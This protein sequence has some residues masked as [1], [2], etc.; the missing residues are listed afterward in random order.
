[1]KTILIHPPFGFEELAGNTASMK[2]VMNIIPP[3]G[4]CYIAAVLEENGKEVEIIDCT[5]VD[6][7]HQELL[8]ELERKKPDIVGISSTTP[9]FESTLKTAG[10]VRAALP[11]AIVVIGGVHVT[12]LP[13]ETLSC[14][15][16]DVGV[17]GEGEVTFLELVNHLESK[18]LKDLSKVMG[19]AYR[20]NNRVVITEKRDFIKDLDSLPLPARHLLPSL[21][22][23]H[24]TPASYR[25]LPH[26]DLMTSRGCPSL[27]TF[28][29]RAVFGC[30][31]RG[32]SAEN[33][34]DEVEELIRKYR[35]RDIKFFDDT[36]T[37]DRRRL[38]RICEL[39]HERGIDIP[40]SCLTKVNYV[41]KEMLEKM[42]KAGC[43]QVLYGI[44]S[45]DPH[46]LKILKKGTTVEQNEQAIRW[47]QQVGLNVRADFIMGTP[48][49]ALE[50]MEK[51][52]QFAMRLNPD[53]AHFNKFTPYPGT[54][55][56]HN[57]VA[58]GYCFDFTKA[59]SQLD[60]SIIMYCPKGVDPVDY[61]NFIDMAYRRYYLRP[62]YI[63]RQLKQ[64]RSFEDIRRMWK[65]FFAIVGL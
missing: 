22:K 28:C 53:F 47:A 1:M 9:A 21:E 36:F 59:C 16:F 61:R 5:P 10:M 43:W 56:Y 50:S 46:M 15:L 24:P 37:L 65:G 42:R 49:D 41:T 32:R 6:T 64:I 4:I 19:I 8:Y 25:R 33:V 34:M 52:L 63:L 55:I 23:Y 3:L 12:A 60:H 51:T 14:G 30:S 27:C 31:Y 58:Q 44:E 57:L 17:L 35:V 62:A 54:E 29:D 40:W 39:F 18:K 11:D 45:G 38:D 13:E 48:G 2:S 26:A 20:K 7:S